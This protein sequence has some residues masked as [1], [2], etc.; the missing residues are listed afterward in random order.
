MAAAKNA[1]KDKADKPAEAAPA[2]GGKGKLIGLGALALLLGLAGGAGGVGYYLTKVAPAKSIAITVAPKPKKE[3]EKPSYVEIDRMIVPL[4]EPNGELNGYLSLDVSME[5]PAE[6]AD[7]VKNRQPLIRH[8]IN[9]LLST[10]SLRSAGGTGAIDYP[11][12]AA[13]LRDAANKA[14]G[15]G[16]VTR[17]DILSALP[18]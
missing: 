16:M 7:F 2:K 12:A 4:L 6:H 3:P 18:V 9:E 10:T 5:V 1:D 17:V 15:P 11:R 13:L 14:L 8:S